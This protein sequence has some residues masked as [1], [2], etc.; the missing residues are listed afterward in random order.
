[1][2]DYIFKKDGKN[3]VTVE[4]KR[5]EALENKVMQLID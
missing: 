5:I 1:M 3:H 2:K 4:A